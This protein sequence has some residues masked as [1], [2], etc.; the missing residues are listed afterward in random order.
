ML[1]AAI[2]RRGDSATPPPRRPLLALALALAGGVSAGRAAGLVPSVAMSAALAAGALALLAARRSPRAAA[3]A[4]VA[5]GLLSGMTLDASARAGTLAEERSVDAVPDG[6]L[7]R[8]RLGILEGPPRFRPEGAGRDPEGL[9]G[10]RLPSATARAWLETLDYG[11]G[12]RP[13][14]GEARL[15]F[16]RGAADLVPGDRVEVAG[17]WARPRPPGNP[18]EPGPLPGGP[19]GLVIVAGPEAA[20]PAPGPA[21]G[22]PARGAALVRRAA[23]DALAAALPARDAGLLSCLLLGEREGIPEAEE[24]AFQ[25]SGTVHVLSVSGL[26]VGFVAALWALLLG[27]APVRS[28]VAAGATL[29]LTGGYLLVAGLR[30]P[31]LRAGIMAAAFLGAGLIGRRRDAWTALSAAAAI[32]LVAAPDDLFRPGWQLTFSAV[33]ALLLL[34]APLARALG[35]RDPLEAAEPPRG[36]VRRF[37][38]LARAWLTGALAASAAATIGTAPLVLHHFGI[39]TPVAL[40]SNLVVVPLV[41]AL[42]VAGILALP[43]V[44]LGGPVAALAGLPLSALA[45]AVR[46]SAGA[47]AS[48]PGAWWALPS[49]GAA[50]T[51]AAL[52]G[53]AAVGTGAAR[54]HPRW[55]A[56]ALAVAAALALADAPE[57]DPPPPASGSVTLLDVG[58]GSATLLRTSAG[59]RILVDAGSSS[60]PGGGARTLTRALLALGVGRLDLLALSHADSDHLNAVPA[61]AD[62]FPIGAVWAGPAVA[63]TAPGRALLAALAGRGIPVRTAVAGDEVAGLAPGERLTVLHPVAAVG[64]LEAGEVPAT[65]EAAAA[66]GGRRRRPALRGNEAS[67][68]LRFEAGGCVA[69]LPGDVEEAGTAAL[70]ARARADPGFA[71]LLRAH[72]HVAPHHGARN[73]RLPEL[74]DA[75]GPNL[76]LISAGRAFPVGDTLDLSRARG[77]EPWLT[78]RDGAVRALLGPEGVRAVSLNPFPLSR[79]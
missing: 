4:L 64:A 42:L 67:L 35:R 74:L 44:L 63:E 15:V 76:L 54:R 34:S 24:R 47:F 46:A 73:T 37:T 17:R 33:A 29:L 56:A 40:L 3:P 1:D 38:R 26:H 51:A 59:Q 58:Q 53:I 70:L 23:E 11:A 32:L 65:G 68:V 19:V 79:R 14:R 57:P 61:L 28:R 39:V 45:E 8:A 55:S 20:V 50:W 27:A 12:P 62:A 18:G 10:V 48:L 78:A 16:S 2:G 21:A 41:G 43:L 22:G 7:V 36:P 25:R 13:A 5:V 75:V 30:A 52:G 66:G 9:P 6:A 72:V 71:R 77:I 49:P 69:L 60:L 31:V